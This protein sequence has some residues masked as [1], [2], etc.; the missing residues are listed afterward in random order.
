MNPSRAFVLLKPDCS[1]TDRRAAVDAAVAAEGL[2]VACRHPVSLTPADV[3][4]LWS[5]YTEDGHVLMHAFLGRYLC[6]APSEV[7]LLRGPDAFAAARRIKRAIRSRY[8]NGPFANLIHA[9]EHPGELARQANHLL[10]HCPECAAPF[11]SSEPLTSPPRPAGRDFRGETDLPAL[12]ESLWP[13]LQSVDPSAPVPYC[14]DRSP[15]AAVYLGADRAH[16]L[17]SAVTALWSAL[18]GITLAHA[19][20]LTLYAGRVGGCPVAVGSHEAV[21]RSH[22][23]LQAHGITTCGVGPAPS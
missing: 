15:V 4:F 14:L 1:G 2:V 23:V 8:A 19:V 10:G 7:L 13:A 12:V 11:V 21:S 22:R 6:T 16:T 20:L 5:E 18:P 9:A 3:R 17:D